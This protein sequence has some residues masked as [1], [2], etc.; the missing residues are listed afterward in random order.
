G[1]VIYDKFVLELRY[2]ITSNNY[3]SIYTLAF[4]EGGNTWAYYKDY[5]L[6]NLKRSAG[7]GF[8]VY[9]P[10]I[11]GT[12]IGFDWGY[13]FDRKPDYKEKDKLK[14]HISIGIGSR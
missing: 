9:L 12:T 4:A 14:L 5:N 10:L 2:P 1:G 3:T 8:R 13:G 7:V 6:F 11:I